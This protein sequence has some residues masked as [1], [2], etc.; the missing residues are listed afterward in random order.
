M[1]NLK[2]LVSVAI[3]FTLVLCNLAWSEENAKTTLFAERAPYGEYYQRCVLPES[4]AALEEKVRHEIW[5]KGLIENFNFLDQYKKLVEYGEEGRLSKVIYVD[6]N[7][8]ETVSTYSYGFNG[9]ELTSVTISSDDGA[10]IKFSKKENGQTEISIVFLQSNGNQNRGYSNTISLTPDSENHTIKDR[11]TPEKPE[12]DIIIVIDDPEFDLNTIAKEPIDFDK[13]FHVFADV[14]KDLGKARDEYAE[15]T[16]PYYEKILEELTAK[17]DSLESEGI[18]LKPYFSRGLGNNDIKEGMKRRLIDEAVEYV[19]SEV[20]KKEDVK[21]V[22][23]DL[24]RLEE[25]YS[26]EF[27]RL[28]KDSYESKVERMREYIQGIIDE[29]LTSKLAIYMNKKKEKI[30]VIINLPEL[31]E[32]II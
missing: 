11:N 20:A 12:E 22:A 26:E 4:K 31:E 16:E 3:C 32:E 10:K 8:K 24:I 30:D 15:D 29:L 5:E 21:V 1:N 23:G 19:H 7:G 28:S 14:D 18:D 6:D 17:L 2:R 9:Q 27:L 25:R 13:F